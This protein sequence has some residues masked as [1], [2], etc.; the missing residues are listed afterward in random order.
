MIEIRNK[1]RYPISL[2]IKSRRRPR[3]MA[4]INICSI[5]KGKNIYLLDD[6]LNTEYVDKAAA[7]G[8]I[9]IKRIPSKRA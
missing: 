3:G 8:D 4:I 9:E 1:R 6:E 7:A 5:G 2:I